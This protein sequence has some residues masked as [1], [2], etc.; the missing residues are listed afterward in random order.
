MLNSSIWARFCQ[1]SA[2]IYVQ[3]DNVRK[4]LN[5]AVSSA[6]AT[7]IHSV[8][9]LFS[10]VPTSMELWSEIFRRTYSVE[11]R[12]EREQKSLEIYVNDQDHYDA[13]TALVYQAEGIDPNLTIYKQPPR[14]P[15]IMA[16]IHWWLRRINGKV[17]SILRL[18]KAAIT[19]E[20]GIDY[21]AWKIKR[22]SGVELDVKPWMRKYPI[23]AGLVCFWR[24]KKLDAF[25]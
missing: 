20:G 5:M 18:I 1:P 6:V 4:S 21:V 16:Y 14:M 8:L 17:V 12:A 19:F 11:F 15:I 13:L 9:P 3:D 10:Y 23:I 22:H 24:M 2:L 7:A 25:R